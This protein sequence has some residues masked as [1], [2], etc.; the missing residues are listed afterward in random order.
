MEH[1]DILCVNFIFI[2]YINDLT[3]CC[4]DANCNI[5]IF[6]DDGKCFSCIKSY[7]DCEK[8][9]STLAA[10]EN[11]SIEW[12]LQLALSKCQVISF[13]TKIA[14]IKFQYSILNYPLTCVDTISDLGVILSSDLSFNRQI[15]KL[16][17]RA[18]CRSAMILKCFQSRDKLLLFRAFIAYVR[19]ILEYCCNVWSPYRLCDI[20]KLESVQRLFTKR[21][22][23]LKD[24]SYP[25]R[26]KCLKAESLEIRR[27]KSD[28]SMY[29]KILHGCVDMDS[30]T[31]FQ[32][33][34]MRTRSDGLTLHK[35]KFS[36]NIERYVFKNRCLNIWN[37]LSQNVVNSNEISIFN[38][39]LSSIDLI[40]IIR[41]ASVLS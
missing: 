28:L 30:D 26:L 39:R 2:L 1:I 40:S 16:Y 20:R 22:R 4:L 24:L 18:R 10:I 17:S 9:Q 21:L 7:Q 35:A 31:L 34:D 13:Y 27:V 25:E 36:C 11:W 19:P 3:Q 29:F 37:L 32:V 33:R 6:A 12:Q 14:H 8:L 5:F 23:G 15:D 41:K 38:N